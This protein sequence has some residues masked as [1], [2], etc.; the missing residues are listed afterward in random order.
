MSAGLGDGFVF[1]AECHLDQWTIFHVFHVDGGDEVS[2]HR[3][4]GGLCC[5]PGL[6]EILILHGLHGNRGAGEIT[7]LALHKHL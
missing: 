6:D 7:E 5:T 1:V 4:F 3:W 2:D